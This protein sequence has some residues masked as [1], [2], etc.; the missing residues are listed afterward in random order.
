MSVFDSA[1]AT[2]SATIGSIMGDDC[3]HI[4]SDYTRTTCKAVVSRG[5]EIIGEYGESAGRINTLSFN[6]S[7]VTPRA[8]DTVTIG[9]DEWKL[10]RLLSD[11]GY[12]M[13][14]EG[15]SG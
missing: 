13:R 7:E 12:W 1:S 9:G 3:V 8:G 11:D 2:A 10:G 4:A 15:V 6:R 5:V 14:F